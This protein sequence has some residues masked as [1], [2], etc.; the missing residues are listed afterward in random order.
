MFKNDLNPS[1]WRKLR[2]W[3]V[4]FVGLAALAFW[5]LVEREGYVRVG[6]VH[7]PGLKLFTLL[8][9]SPL[10]AEGI[11]RAV[12]RPLVRRGHP[13]WA[14]PAVVVVAGYLF[15]SHNVAFFF[16]PADALRSVLFV[17]IWPIFS[18]FWFYLILLFV[19]GALVL[20]FLYGAVAYEL[21]RKEMGWRSLAE[22]DP[23]NS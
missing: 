21:V 2:L 17:V 1:V 23:W 22:E 10:F 6:S 19:P 16:D 7:R 15:M 14:G 4:S 13:V 8:L 11:F 9:L 20:G 18:F 5:F 3:N 12:L